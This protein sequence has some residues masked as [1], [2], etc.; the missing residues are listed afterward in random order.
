MTTT[1]GTSSGSAA[2]IG[3]RIALTLVGAAGLIVGAFMD[4]TRS[5]QGTKLD[6]QAFWTTNFHTTQTFVENVGIRDD[7]ARPRGGGRA[8]DGHG[9]AYQARGCDRGGRVRPVRDRGL[10]LV[11]STTSIGVGA[12]LALAGGI[13]TL[14]A[15]FFGPASRHHRSDEHRRRGRVTPQPCIGPCARRARRPRHPGI[16]CPPCRGRCASVSNSPRSNATCAGPST[17]RWRARPRRWGSTRSGSATICSTA[18]TDDPSAGR[19]KR[20]RCSRGSRR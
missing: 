11:R 15:G 12:W 13:V 17:R 18:T 10:S 8:G 2:A 3:T 14:F 20:G 16:H 1:Y 5:I 19:G 7:R 6:V 4:W 9:L